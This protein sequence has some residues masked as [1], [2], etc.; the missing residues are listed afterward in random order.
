MSEQQYKNWIGRELQ[1]LN[2]IIDYNILHGFNY[3]EES[4]K[5]K[6]LLKQTEVMQ[7]KEQKRSVFSFMFS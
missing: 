4:K 5:H 1:R 7:K 3:R 6:A 2:E